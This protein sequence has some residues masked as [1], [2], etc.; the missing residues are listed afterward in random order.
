VFAV[1]LTVGFFEVQDMDANGNPISPPMFGAELGYNQ[2]R[3]IRHRFFAI[4]DRSQLTGYS[5]KDGPGGPNPPYNVRT[6]TKTVP[7]FT[8]IK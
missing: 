7:Y 2:G 6:D 3:Q 8:V 1:W 5:P 4:V